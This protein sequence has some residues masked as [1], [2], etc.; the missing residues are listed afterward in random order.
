MSAYLFR[1]QRIAQRREPAHY[2]F[3]T[4]SPPKISPPTPAPPPPT[5]DMAANSQKQ[6]DILR[7]RRGA[8]ANVL[9]GQNPTAPATT[10]IAKLLGT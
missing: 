3:G 6:G 4:P 10:G 2:Y 5:V 8:S 7:Q 9:A 1:L